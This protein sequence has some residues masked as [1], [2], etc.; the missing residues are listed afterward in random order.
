MIN[1]NEEQNR[2]PRNVYCEVFIVFLVKLDIRLIFLK[3]HSNRNAEMN[4]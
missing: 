2:M 3:D 1:V 4:P